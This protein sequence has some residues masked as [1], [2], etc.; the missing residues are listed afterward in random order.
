MP[1]KYKAKAYR[2]PPKLKA[3]SVLGSKLC[4]VPEVRIV[5][6]CL[7][8]AMRRA[9]SAEARN[10]AHRRA[11]EAGAAISRAIERIPDN[12]KRKMSPSSMRLSPEVVYTLG[13]AARVGEFS[14]ADIVEHCISNEVVAAV[15]EIIEEESTLSQE[16]TGKS[17][18]HMLKAAGVRPTPYPK[19][20]AAGRERDD[21]DEL[22]SERALE[23][24][25][26]Y[27]HTEMIPGVGSLGRFIPK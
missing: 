23:M 9:V 13:V 24:E 14:E 17:F 5:E 4:K 6:K 1:T 12:A 20:T 19:R 8:R 7:E 26:R 11:L 21:S 27:S 10:S 18:A 3:L 15:M 2:L 25:R 16:S 22:T